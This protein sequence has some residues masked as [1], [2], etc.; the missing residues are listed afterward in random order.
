MFTL[1]NLLLLN[2]E[3]ILKSNKQKS[4]VESCTGLI[5][6]ER[7]Q[8][9]IQRLSRPFYWNIRYNP[10]IR[11]WCYHKLLYL[12]FKF[13]VSHAFRKQFIQKP[14]S[15]T[16]I[17]CNIMFLAGWDVEIDRLFLYSFHKGGINVLARCKLTSVVVLYFALGEFQK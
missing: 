13:H 8:N 17:F 14:S 10:Y 16:W 15:S 2:T 11:V 7:L 1:R 3:A 6:S 4:R 12:Q 5:Q 9:I